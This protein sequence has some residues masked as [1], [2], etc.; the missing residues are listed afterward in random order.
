MSNPALLGLLL[1]TALFTS[2][3]IAA[4]RPTTTTIDYNGQTY[5]LASTSTCAD[6]TAALRYQRK[7]WCPQITT[8][9]PPP[10]ST[11]VTY[12]A[13]LS[14]TAPTIRE[15]GTPLALS[16]L[17]GYEIYY[18]SDDPA[19][20]GTITIAGGSEASYVLPNLA[21]GN[22]YFTISAID[23]NG[24]KSAMSA[25]VSAHFGN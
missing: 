6:G 2:E 24:L 9:T 16:E 3:T 7:W 22:Y 13:Q 11:P 12:N 8:V 1:L 4:K 14:W 10:T 19:V 18:T 23:S 20:A 5:T 17:A 25:L 15:D 21:A